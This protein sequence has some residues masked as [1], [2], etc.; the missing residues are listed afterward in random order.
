MHD[1]HRVEL[2]PD[3]WTRLD[4]ADSRQQKCGEALAVSET[5]PDPC[6]DLFQELRARRVFEQAHEGLDPR[7][8]PHDPGIDPRLCGR[9]R[10]QAC[11]E[12]ELAVTHER[13]GTGMEKVAPVHDFTS[14]HQYVASGFQRFVSVMP[15]PPDSDLPNGS[16]RPV[17]KCADGGQHHHDGD[18]AGQT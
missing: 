9:D 12:R 5:L 8:E 13:A 18:V 4:I 10:L 11:E 1:H 15:E 14:P 6:T 16:P 3:G 17:E 7:V 2:E